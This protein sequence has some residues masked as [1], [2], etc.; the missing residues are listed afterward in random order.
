MNVKHLVLTPGDSLARR[1][2][3]GYAKFIAR[4]KHKIKKGD[5]R[6]FKLREEEKSGMLF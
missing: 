4:M 2:D 5:R 1:F 6:G 3:E